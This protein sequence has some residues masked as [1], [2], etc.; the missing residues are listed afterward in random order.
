MTNTDN[1]IDSRDIIDRIDELEGEIESLNEEIAEWESDI[2]EKEDQIEQLVGDDDATTSFYEEIEDIKRDIGAR[3]D[4]IEEIQE[5]LTP[6][7]KLQE[8]AQ[9]YCPDWRYGATLIRDDYFEEY[10]EELAEDI[11]AIDR[12]ATWPLNHIDWEAAANELKLDYTEIDY[13]GQSYWI[14]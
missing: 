8:E 11:G 9:G 12:N 10:A 4:Q 13:D 1:I 3:K 7:L 14:R 5:E 6:L 2:E